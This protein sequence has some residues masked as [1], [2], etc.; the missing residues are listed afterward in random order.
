MIL[1]NVKSALNMMMLLCT[2]NLISIFQNYFINFSGN[3]NKSAYLIEDS[4]VYDIVNLM[5]NSVIFLGN[6]VIFLGN[7][8]IFLGNNVIH[9]GKYCNIFMGTLYKM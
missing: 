3:C 4:I 2:S 9:Y 5:G 8:V 7:S 1:E 6:N